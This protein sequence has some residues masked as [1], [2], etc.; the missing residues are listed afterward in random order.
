M[1]GVIAISRKIS[2][3]W[4][5]RLQNSRNRWAK[6]WGPTCDRDISNSAIYT[7]AIY[8]AYTVPQMNVKSWCQTD[9]RTACEQV[10]DEVLYIDCAEAFDIALMVT[11]KVH[12]LG[13]TIHLDVP[14]WAWTP[15]VAARPAAQRGQSCW[16]HTP[17]QRADSTGYSHWTCPT[18]ACCW[19]TET[20][21][22]QAE[23]IMGSCMGQLDLH[24]AWS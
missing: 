6:K 19:R 24:C 14:P 13:Q 2:R 4:A 23:P 8:R 10:N 17:G 3:S 1:Q 7:T 18:S 5:P 22:M 21:M 9:I 12:T 16:A 20:A 15:T 11:M